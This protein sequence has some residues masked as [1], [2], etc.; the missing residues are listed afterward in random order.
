MSISV[1]EHHHQ[2]HQIVSSAT[3]TLRGRTLILGSLLVVFSLGLTWF[4]NMQL[5]RANQDVQTIARASI[6]SVDAA[7]SLATLLQDLDASAADYLSA[8]GLHEL[9]PCILPSETSSIGMFTNHDCDARAIPLYVQMMNNQI[10]LAIRNV[11]YPGEKTALLDTQNGLEVYLEDISHMQED[12]ELGSQSSSHQYSDLQRAYADDMAAENVLTQHISTEPLPAYEP[13][14]SLPSC[15]FPGTNQTASAAI[16]T[17]GSL[18]T[19]VRCLAA[20]NQAHLQQ[21]YSDSLTFLTGS[22]FLV[23]VAS[24]IFVLLLVTALAR[25]IRLSRR[26]IQML[27]SLAVLLALGA[28]VYSCTTL[29]SLAGNTGAFHRMVISDRVSID[30]A[31]RIR[32]YGTTANADE[33]RY[34]IAENFNDASAI[35]RWQDDWNTNSAQVMTDMRV[36]KNNITYHPAE[37][38]AY[39][40]MA[41]WWSEYLQ[42]DANIRSAIKNSNPQDPNRALP[43]QEISTGVSDKDFGSFLDATNQLAQV[44][45]H[46][47]EQTL[48]EVQNLLG[49][50][51][52]LVLILLPLSGLCTFISS[53][54]FARNEL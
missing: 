20:I 53:F 21:A 12:Y 50:A 11:T 43:A 16:W 9:H 47:Y 36:A 25:T 1:L 49:Y 35:V 26:R 2:D 46:D 19:Q 8:A 14:A 30:A 17:Q 18:Q 24:L 54:L 37:D 13:I 42:Q 22:S 31:A 40:G 38:N 27:L 23:A 33:S 48:T 29:F 39:A 15:T 45:Q 4:I 28:C 32:D 6:P 51:S 34:L 41:H 52:L 10:Y 7:E 44:N 5:A 3:T